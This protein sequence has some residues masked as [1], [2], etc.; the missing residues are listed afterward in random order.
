M[1]LVF[2]LSPT[3]FVE[4]QKDVPPGKVPGTTTILKN[5]DEVSIDL[6]AHK[7]RNKPVLDLKPEDLQLT[8]DGKPVTLSDLRLVSGRSVDRHFISFVF[9]RLGP[10]GAT[11]AREIA[12]KILK[13]IPTESFSFSVFSVAGRLELLQGF[14]GDRG[15][16]QKAVDIAAGAN[17]A[18]RDQSAGGSEKM[19]VAALRSFSGQRRAP[20]DDRDAERAELAALADSQRITEEENATPALAGLL[21]LAGTQAG[22]HGRKLL[23]FFTAGLRSDDD[24][25]DML[26]SIAGAAM[27]ANVSI[28]V[29]NITPVDT[30]V[31]QGLMESQAM[32][33]LAAFNRANPAPTGP[34]A[35]T[36]SVFAGGMVSM[37][38][39]QITR[40]EGEGLEGK[41]D[42]VAAMASSTGGAYLFLEDNVK[43]PF[44]RAVAD[45]SSYY[46]ASYV[47][48][49]GQFDGKF[50]QVKVKVLRRGLKVRARAGYFAVPPAEGMR[51]YEL[52]LMKIFSGPQVPAEVQFRAAVLR[53]GELS[54]GNEN[55][56]VVEVP[57]SSL[58]TQSDANTNLLSWHVLIV[59]EIKDKSGAIIEHFSDDIPGHGTVGSKDEI[60]FNCATMQRHFSLSPGIYTL[61]TA[62]VD[63]ISGKIGGERTTFE[64]AD[65]GSGPFLS[66]LALV[67]RIDPYPY[68]LDP[69]EP[70][71]YE[72]GR[73]VPSLSASVPPGTK[74]LSFFF[75]VH[76]ES[77]GSSPAIL[78]M[79]VLRNG[80]L[81]GQMPLQLPKNL[82]D[83]FPYVASLKTASLSAGDYDVRLSLSQ[84]GQVSERETSFTIPG[85]ELATAGL[86][87]IASTGQS[88]QTAAM[89]SS[90]PG[91]G[92]APA[93]REPL[94]ITTLS[95][96]SVT[97]PSE[98]DLKGLIAGARKY[99]TNYAAKL[100]NFLCVEITD[101]AVAPS[102]NGQWR[103]KDSFAEALRFV[104]NQEI[105]RTLEFN[106]HP[107]TK[108]RSDME[109]P[110][111][112][113]EFGDLLSAVFLPGSKAEFH[114]KETDAL[115]HGRVQVFEY[116]VERKNNSMLL[117]DSGGRI[118]VGF[119]GQVYIDS[120]TMGV[121]RITMEADDLSPD[122]S[123]H[124]AS[125]AVDYDYVPVGKHEYLMPIRGTIRVQRGRR[126][127]DLNQIVFQD[128]RRY[129]STVKISVAP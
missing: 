64:V 124:A 71:R 35:Q 108:K 9:D 114:W 88:E 116:R 37:V 16:V 3:V 13:L 19:L 22:I 10:S 41:S 28:Y 69:L 30:K 56:L 51:P 95:P 126:E 102:G 103:R 17:D 53:L 123:I 44:R 25:R 47:P 104:N 50:H 6:V 86:G 74:D 94:V 73:V 101:R 93:G 98:D 8:D 46:E 1:S 77:T 121:R 96:D 59:S 128:Y 18:E 125:V 119:H 80:E 61:E 42:P 65:S 32:G 112:L 92:I 36:P 78:E 100:P 127:V 52:A 109:G 111:S 84:N 7:G 43:K 57:I 99:A 83:A 38:Q 54:I 23:V 14:T 107:S 5:V 110:I 48:P 4:A 62:V 85:A 113:G 33:A 115:E 117:S 90:D 82:H 122:F 15:A 55:T 63:R 89:T 49:K 34:L 120:A 68:E 87:K 129:A 91:T 29:V 45:L 72:H 79:E 11:D 20:G 75:L 21:A 118:Y 58:E 39:N 76:P 70:L 106:G 60:E 105:R 2:V 81:L 67:R 40:S 12:K 27:R 31:M 24:T 97:R 26:R 66:D